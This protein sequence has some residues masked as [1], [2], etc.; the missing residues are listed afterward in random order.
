MGFD[1]NSIGSL[2][3]GD[4]L[5]AI[6]ERA[7]MDQ[8]DVAKVLSVGIPALVGGMNRNVAGEE[9][10]ESLSRALAQHESADISKPG[11]FLLESDLDDGKKIVGHVFGDD[12]DEAVDEISRASGVSKSNVSTILALAA[13]LLLSSLGQQSS[14]SS[15]G[16]LLG[17]LLGGGL[18]GSGS[19]NPLMSLLGGLLG[20]GSTQQSTAAQNAAAQNAYQQGYMQGLM[21]QQQNAYQQNAYQNAYQNTYQQNQQGFTLQST[22]PQQSSSSGFDLLGNLLGGGG[23]ASSSG[24][25]STLLGGGQAAQQS[26]EDSGFLSGLLNLLH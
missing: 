10:A 6:A 9:G 8:K 4:G 24:L 21:Q 14:Q 16:G 5:S 13:P 7:N 12:Q 3:A 23:A 22:M 25:F 15:S 19:S 20:M 11:E 2:F 1:M 17:G 26:Q 18:G